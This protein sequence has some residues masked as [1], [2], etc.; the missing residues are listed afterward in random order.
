MQSRYRLALL[1]EN[2]QLFVAQKNN[3]TWEVLQKLLT[4]FDDILLLQFADA[5]IKLQPL[6]FELCHFSGKVLHSNAWQHYVHGDDLPYL[7]QLLSLDASESKSEVTLTLRLN[8]SA[9]MVAR[10]CILESHIFLD[11]PLK[12]LRIVS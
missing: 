10:K 1:N 4:R 12:V 7:L 9:S 3:A 5:N 11:Q 8:E 6:F 2:D